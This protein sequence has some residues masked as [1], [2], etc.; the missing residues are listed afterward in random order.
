[1]LSR[2][3][4]E[5]KRTE[6]IEAVDCPDCGAKAGERCGRPVGLDGL[7]YLR[8]I[9]FIKSGLAIDEQEEDTLP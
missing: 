6:V 3:K 4:D 2:S 8:R 5:I 9:A 1:M 7:H